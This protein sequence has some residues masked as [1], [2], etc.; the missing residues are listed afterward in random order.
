MDRPASGDAAGAGLIG[1]RERATLAGGRVDAAV[2]ED[3]RFQLSGWLP[4]AGR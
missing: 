3:D 2:T 1:L 4:W